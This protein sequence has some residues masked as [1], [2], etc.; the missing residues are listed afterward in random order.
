MTHDRIEH[1]RNVH[2][3]GPEEVQRRSLIPVAASSQ[4]G[5][6]DTATLRP[7]PVEFRPALYHFALS[8]NKGNPARIVKT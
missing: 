7:Q 2:G 8:T 6:H 3:E 4:S 5:S 1:Q